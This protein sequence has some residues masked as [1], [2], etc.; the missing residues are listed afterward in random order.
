MHSNERTAGRRI[1][2]ALLALVFACASWQA[3]AGKPYLYYAVGDPAKTVSVKAPA[4]RSYVMMGGGLEVDEA[5]RW[6]IKQAGVTRFSGGRFLVIRAT[7]DDAYNQYLFSATCRY[8]TCVDGASLGLTS[9]ETL[10]IPSRDAANHADVIAYVS[11]ANVLW[12]AGGDQSDY[13]NFW[14]GTRLDG[15]LNELLGRKIPFGGLSAG[16]AVLGQFDYA[17]QRASAT[18][19][20]ALNDP[21]NNNMTLDPVPLA[22]TGGFI[23]PPVLASAITDTHLDTRDR[24]GRLITFVARLVKPYQPPPGSRTLG[25]PGGVLPVAQ[26]RGV[27]VSIQTALLLEQ[28]SNGKV[29]AQVMAN[30]PDPQ[31]PLEERSAYLVR[32]TEGATACAPGTPLSI[33][34]GK[35]EVRKLENGARFVDFSDWSTI[36]LYNNFGIDGGVPTD[37]MLY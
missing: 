18:S 26:A 33:G 12:I 20:D 23:A 4:S 11:R 16:M 30:P 22:L 34:S 29:W 25:C 36:P 28:K 19:T 5:F 35:V 31:T 3:H 21:F 37:E 27:G 17:G 10:V 8:S 32:L 9:V 14:K 2:R 6:M 13:I 7:G 1:S 15:A 24:M